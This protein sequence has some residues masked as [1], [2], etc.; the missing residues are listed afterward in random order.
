MDRELKADLAI[1]G[2]STGG[3]AAALAA[4]KSGKKVILTEETDWIG[5]QFTSQ[6]VPPD[7]HSYIERFG[8]TDSYRQFRNR[9]RDYYRRNFP[10]TSAARNQTFF[11]PGN[12]GVGKICASPQITLAVLEEMFAP[13]LHSGLLTILRYCKIMSADVTHDRINWVTLRETNTHDTF[14]IRAQYFLDATDCGELLPLAG[15]EYITG[16]ESQQQTGEPHALPGNPDPFDMQAV[17]HCFAVDYIAGEDFT[18]S[19]P[20][21]YDF[22]HNYQVAF[23][24]DRQLSW[25]TPHHITHQPLKWS[26]WGEDNGRNMFQYRRIIDQSNFLP[27]LFSS[28]ITIINVPQTDYFLGPVFETTDSQKHLNAAKQLSL[29]FLYWLQTE[30]PRPDEGQGYKG[31]R[32]RP[33]IMGTSDGMAKSIYIRESLRIQAEFRICEQHLSPSGRE[34]HHA[35]L[36]KDSVGIGLYR[37]DLHPST[38]KRNYIDIDCLPF[39]IPLGSMIPVRIDNVLPACKNIGT[40]HIT[41]GCFRLH[42]VEWNIGESAG[43]LAAYCITNKVIP[44]QVKNDPSR[45]AELQSYLKK[46]GIELTWPNL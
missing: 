35:E 7:E 43:Y 36:F 32:L 18:I 19:K 16:A 25:F 30:A 34:S 5:G 45:L 13:Y 20:D 4:V 28:D 2:G 21:D 46:G 38:G 41:N 8:C 22:W 27:G 3:C 24:P 14:T 37:M 44:R 31:L 39:Q 42:P 29:A 9:I 1:I 12:N 15:V 40:T 11:H 33:D 6:G 23:W 26:L 17:S 10:L